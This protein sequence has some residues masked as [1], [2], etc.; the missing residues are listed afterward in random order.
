MI[1]PFKNDSIYWFSCLTFEFYSFK[2]QTNTF[3]CPNS[4]RLRLFILS[5][6]RNFSF[7]FHRWCS[8]IWPRSAAGSFNN[9]FALI[10]NFLKSSVSLL[11][12]AIL[13][14]FFFLKLFLLSKN[15][16]LNIKS[17]SVK[18]GQYPLFLMLFNKKCQNPKKNHFDTFFEKSFFSEFSKIWKFF[19]IEIN[20][21][22]FSPFS[23]RLGPN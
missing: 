6:H 20:Q 2:L 9:L 23:E 15:I 13:L 18:I 4:I 11:T 12:N 21:I 17:C 1:F 14:L 19:G 3:E 22:F 8:W 16:F 10:F 5:N 7:S